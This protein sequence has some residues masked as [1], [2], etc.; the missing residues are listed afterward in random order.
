MRLQW[1]K[2]DS[3]VVRFSSRLDPNSLL[4]QLQL[5]QPDCSTVTD[6]SPRDSSCDG[7]RLKCE[8]AGESDSPHEHR[9]RVCFAHLII[10]YREP[11]VQSMSFVLE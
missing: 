2:S 8:L 6:L 7:R 4:G 1:L 5:Y 9:N 10:F 3:S 11:I